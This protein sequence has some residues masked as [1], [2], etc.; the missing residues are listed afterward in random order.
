M[1]FDPVLQMANRGPSKVM[2]YA[3]ESLMIFTGIDKT[4]MSNLTQDK[5]NEIVEYGRDRGIAFNPKKTEVMYLGKSHG[6]ENPQTELKCPHGRT[7]G[8]HRSTSDPPRKP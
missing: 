3:D 4:T 8:D 2:G 1:Y 5:I 6:A 7:G